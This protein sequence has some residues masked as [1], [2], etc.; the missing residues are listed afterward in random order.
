MMTVKEVCTEFFKL[1]NEHNLNYIKIQK[2]YP[3]ELVRLYL[4]Y[5]ITRKLNIFSS[6][7]QSSVSLFDKFKSFLPFIKNSI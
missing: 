6:A 1:E 7:Q 4:Y 2:V 5:E 3:W